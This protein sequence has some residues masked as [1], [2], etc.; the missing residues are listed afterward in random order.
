MDLDSVLGVDSATETGVEYKKNGQIGL[1]V[2]MYVEERESA[3][4][5]VEG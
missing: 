1:Y 2:S 3:E 4:W 5:S